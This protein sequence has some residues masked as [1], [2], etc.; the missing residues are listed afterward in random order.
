MKSIFKKILQNFFKIIKK[1]KLILNYNISLNPKKI[2]PDH[3]LD[4]YELYLNEERESCYEEFKKYF[5]T[6][7]FIKTKEI[8][9]Y[10]IKKSKKLNPD[11]DLYYLEFGV[12][13]GDSINFLAN[14][15][16]EIYGFDSFIG[17][18]DDWHGFSGVAE[19]SFNLESKLPKVK[20]NVKLIPGW[21]EDNL[22]KFLN[23]KKP[24]ISFVNI[25]VDT[26]NTTRFILEKIKPYLLKN[27]II[28]FDELYNYPGWS[29]GEYK[30]LREI[31]NENDFKFLAFSIDGEQSVIQIL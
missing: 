27:S 18:K 24:K 12:W 7:T 4:V 30:A 6:S 15:C 29:V 31:F 21:I 8:K 20:K 9:K 22:E 1:I 3:L 16:D 10:A 13:K 28:I 14:Y 25:D 26:Y 11:S 19:E 17:L 5:K 23:E 2:I